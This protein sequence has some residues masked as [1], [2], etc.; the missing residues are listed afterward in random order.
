MKLGLFAQPAHPPERSP[1]DCQEWDLQVLRWLDELGYEE[2]WLCEHHTLP[3]EPNPAPDILVA[4]AIRETSRIRLGTGGVCL[5]YHNPAVVANRIAWLDH[6]AQGRLNFGIAAGSVPSDWALLG[7]DGE[8]V[9]DMTR[10]SLEIILKIWGAEEPFDYQGKYWNCRYDEP[11]MPLKGAHIKP[12]QKP[13][14]PIGIS[15]LTARSETL[16]MAGRQGF[17]PMS[18]NISVDFVKTH[19]DA[20]AEGAALAGRT[21]NRADWRV[22]REVVVAETDEAAYKLATEGNLGRFARDYVLN[23]ASR[24]GLLQW[25][26]HDP[27]VPDSDMTV[28]YMAK[29]CWIVGSPNTVREKLEEFQEQSGGFGTLL[30]FGCDYADKASGWHESLRA[31]AEEVAPKVKGGGALEV[32]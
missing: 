31:L 13:Y 20:Y 8:K 26:K 4:Q 15:G 7:L 1:Y 23:V 22:C 6:L 24:F 29:H 12:F 11:E 25:Y 16:K 30:V 5:P 28:D 19:W 2:A 10:E 32:A 21:P 17:I 3:W 14:P 18:L 27:S 9:R